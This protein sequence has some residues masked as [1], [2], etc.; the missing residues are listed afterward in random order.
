MTCSRWFAGLIDAP[1]AL[2]FVI[3]AVVP[4]EIVQSVELTCCQRLEK[5][6]TSCEHGAFPAACRACAS[7]CEE[8]RHGR[9]L[10][11]LQVHAIN[12]AKERQPSGKWS[13]I[14][15]CPWK[16][17]D[18][19]RHE[20][21]FG[22]VGAGFGHLLRLAVIIDRS[23]V[24]VWALDAGRQAN[25]SK[26]IQQPLRRTST[27]AGLRRTAHVCCAGSGSP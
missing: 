22:N 5:R 1:S 15:I 4:T 11:S 16:A 7:K 10:A 26:I 20:R 24:T 25:H 18:H 17:V 23:E 3:S 13:R 6:E 9:E 21:Y 8:G 14:I 2:T 12:H 27:S 19:L